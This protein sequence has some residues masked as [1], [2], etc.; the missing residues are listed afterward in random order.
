M[1]SS[2]SPRHSTSS[3]LEQPVSSSSHSL[4][5][6]RS[7]STGH[8]EAPTPPRTP[9]RPPLSIPDD[10]R[11]KHRHHQVSQQEIR[12][13]AVHRKKSLI[14][15]IKI[16]E[17]IG[18]HDFDGN[19]N[20]DV[21]EHEQ[22]DLTS[23]IR[24]DSTDG[25]RRMNSIERTRSWAE[26]VERN[27]RRHEK[28]RE[29][30]GQAAL[31]PRDGPY[32]QAFWSVSTEVIDSLVEALNPSSSD[33]SHLPSAASVIL[34]NQRRSYR[35]DSDSSES[36]SEHEEMSDRPSPCRSDRYQNQGASGKAG[37]SSSR[38]TEV[39]QPSS[40]SRK[41]SDASGPLGK[42]QLNGSPTLLVPGLHSSVVPISPL[43]PIQ[44][45]RGS[46]LR[47]SFHGSD[48]LSKATENTAATRQ[49][50]ADQLSSVSAKSAPSV[51][52]IDDIV[53]KHSAGVM[54]A[55]DAV[56]EKARREI[57]VGNIRPKSA[58]SDG[59]GSLEEALSPADAS[60]DLQSPLAGTEGDYKIAEQKDQPTQPV[61]LRPIV[62]PGPSVPAPIRSSFTTRM[63][64]PVPP[65]ANSLPLSRPSTLPIQRAG[66]AGFRSDN[67][68]SSKK[69]PDGSNSLSGESL[70][71]EVK[72]GQAL[73]D[74]LERESGRS[75]TPC[76]S[77]RISFQ[78][79]R[80]GTVASRSSTPT[81]STKLSKRRSM[82]N[83]S[84]TAAPADADA[85]A[86]AER[87]AKSHSHA[88]YLRSK[89][90]NRTV[91][92][93]QPYAQRELNVSLAEVGKP[94]GQPVV[95]FLGLGCVRYLI[96]LFDDI[97]RAFNLRL[98][99]IDRWGLGKTNQVSPG[100]RTVMAWAYVV[101]RVLDEIGVKE[102][103][104]LA[105]SAGAPYALACALRM[106][107]R[108]RGKV[109]LLAPWVSASIDGGYKWLKWVPNGVI[110]GATAAEWK[111]QSYLLGKPPPLSYRPISHDARAPLS[112]ASTPMAPG[113]STIPPFENDNPTILTHSRTRKDS[114]ATRASSP[115][116]PGGLVRRASR[117]LAPRSIDH[118]F[119]S[120]PHATPHD[121]GPAS[122]RQ[123]YVPSK[124]QGESPIPSPEFR[125]SDTR[126]TGQ[127]RPRP[128][129]RPDSLYVGPSRERSPSLVP[130]PRKSEGYPR[131]S[132][133]GLGGVQRPGSE[134][135]CV[136]VDPELDLEGMSYILSE[137]FEL[138]A[139]GIADVDIHSRPLASASLP[140]PPS[141]LSKTASSSSRSIEG[142][143]PPPAPTGPEFT[144]AV[145]QA[146]H[147]ECEPGTTSDLFSIV[148]NRDPRP[149]GFEY[150][151]IKNSIKIWYGDE[152][153]KISEKSMRW[154][155]RSM[156]DVELIIRKGE[157][158]SLMTSRGTMWEVFESLGKE[159]QVLQEHRRT[160]GA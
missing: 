127:P 65:R 118:L 11:H 137:G 18:R 83:S 46:P 103:Q 96:A 155:E 14:P 84:M 7:T 151:D 51:M 29:Q 129:P 99:C 87:E 20:E 2:I 31:V 24:R 126:F 4:S 56:K 25:I 123:L 5:L 159:A 41:R 80:R 23:S 9:S 138:G 115:S 146:S 62:S 90:L 38:H 17:D 132:T 39:E 72:I 70:S 16:G 52:S 134:D 152:D 147:A 128:R 22:M 3:G 33:L 95:I 145:T 15:S 82:P 107:Q 74:Q 1:R 102:F 66:N 110:K 47:S 122:R 124:A 58:R 12:N 69:P 92:L 43:D 117:I 48:L 42:D 76:S 108:V 160:L 63:A 27:R 104:I 141:M 109:H 59:R 57:G 131:R 64:P 79:P 111:L 158:H 68:Q 10:V 150:H 53:A 91:T 73:L 144:L 106:G 54:R 97:A 45:L 35:M 89:H 19:G 100:N 112:S 101:E 13:K 157:G 30:D 135:D 21:P 50:Q 153:D 49:I 139:S 86:D 28:K 156:E 114:M 121:N 34:A 133:S 113:T 36:E 71:Q 61:N 130:S 32:G 148:L 119:T 116:K 149:W 37:S 136:E 93:S 78:S 88:V 154:M 77:Q 40:K 44:P 140:V 98:I 6:S 60:G 85:D 8:Q 81:K 94:T 26:E 142:D 105:H 75:S 67:E 143:Y 55:V 120:M 125:N